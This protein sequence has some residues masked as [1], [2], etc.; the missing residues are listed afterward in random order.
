MDNR[1][2]CKSVLLNRSPLI[3]AILLSYFN[4]YCEALKCMS[5]NKSYFFQVM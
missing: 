5:L 1:Y 2:V 3:E 4:C